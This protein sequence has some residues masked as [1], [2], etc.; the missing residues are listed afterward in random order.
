MPTRLDPS[1]QGNHCN[2]IRHPTKTEAEAQRSALETRERTHGRPALN[3]GALNV[4]WCKACQA[5]H[6][7]HKVV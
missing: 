6:V 5:Y 3:L 4:Y 7:G 2:K 1:H